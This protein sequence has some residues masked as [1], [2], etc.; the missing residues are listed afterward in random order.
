[1]RGQRVSLSVPRRIIADIMHISANVPAIPLQREFKL[2]ELVKAR[3]ASPE[4]T[5][6]AALFIKAYAIVADEFPELRRAF[7]RLPWPHLYEYHRSAATLVVER[8]VE[9]E[10]NVFM[11]CI[12]DPTVLPLQEIERRIRKAKNGSLDDAKGYRRAMRLAKFPQF[13]RRVGWWFVFCFP[14]AR[15]NYFGTF[16]VSTVSGLGSDILLP[17]CPLT[18]LLT[19]GVIGDDGRVVVRMIFDHRV[20]DAATGARA[21]ARLEQTLTDT[22]VSEL[23]GDVTAASPMAGAL[24]QAVPS[25]PIAGNVTLRSRVHN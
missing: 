7:V 19:Y 2:G 18:T 20:L 25:S 16:A 15:A 5:S 24:L 17:R 14:R 11:M 4:R 13:L 6:W 9:G 1:L 3:Q 12:N 10:S 23:R 8:Q 22:M 21:L